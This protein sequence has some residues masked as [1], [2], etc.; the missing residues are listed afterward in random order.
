MKNFINYIKE[1]KYDDKD[2]LTNKL[3]DIYEEYTGPYGKNELDEEGY[4]ILKPLFDVDFDYKINFKVSEYDPDEIIITADSEKFC[5]YLDIYVG[6]LLIFTEYNRSYIQYEEFFDDEDIDNKLS[7]EN[8]DLM[9][10]I[11]KRLKIKED[12]NIIEF[13]NFPLFKSIKDEILGDI[14]YF[15]T[16]SKQNY[17]FKIAKQIPFEIVFESENIAMKIELEEFENVKTINELIDSGKTNFDIEDFDY[18]YDVSNDDI[19]EMNKSH[20][21]TL[22]DNLYN[23]VEFEDEIEDLFYR[24]SLYK[25]KY[26]NVDMDEVRTLSKKFGGE[27]KKYFLDD[28]FQTNYIEEDVETYRN[29]REKDILTK[30]VEKKLRYIDRKDIFNLDN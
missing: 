9:E 27:F 11:F 26:E 4:K 29:L 24:N 30:N 7:D 1:N 3:Y 8:K 5:K 20:E 16:T 22:R 25:N 14:D 21:K 18:V 10:K 6:D 19:V 28:E 12:T 17:A 13:I 15:V 2:N 23:K